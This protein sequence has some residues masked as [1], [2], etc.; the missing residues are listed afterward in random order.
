[1]QRGAFQ[2]LFVLVLTTVLISGCATTRARRPDPAQADMS[3][4]MTAMQSEMASKDRQI[5][6][7]QAKLDSYQRALESP[8]TNFSASNA[9]DVIRV[10]GVSI[11]DVQRALKR[12]GFDPGSV[13]GK[14]GKKTKSAIR[15]F[16]R[17]QGL[18][19][20]GVVGQKTWS[21]L[22]R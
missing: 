10:S 8:R 17:S 6:E 16:Q 2:T 21:A 5:A 9:S 20:D 15:E 11:S 19:A 14:L 3:A 7:L 22:N 18:S 13:D 4:Q 1:M 12:A